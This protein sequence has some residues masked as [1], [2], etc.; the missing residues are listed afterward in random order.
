MIAAWMAAV[1]TTMAWSGAIMATERMRKAK[2][3]RAGAPKQ[4]WLTGP[5]QWLL[6]RSGALDKM[7]PLATGL[8]GKLLIL[9]GQTWSAE[10]SR[11]FI[12]ES[13]GIGYAALCA[14]TWLAILSGESTLLYIGLLLGVLVPAAKW[15]DVTGKVE[16]RKQD[17]VLLLPELLNKLMLLLGAGETLHRALARCAERNESH[18]HHPL[19]IELRRVNEAVRN[20]Q[21][22]AAAME[23]FSR[24]CGVQEVSV[25]TTTMLLNYKRGGDRLVLSLKE[26]SY[27]LWEKR[28]AVARSRGEEASAKLVFPLVGLFVVLMVLVAS[29][30]ILMMRG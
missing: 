2:G 5:C 14:G 8:H 25:F 4:R 26:L 3:I 6:E 11:G 22:F 19:L 7:Q 17:I 30:A 21:S 1:L 10:A 15:K 16:R 18:A 9:H 20:G 12:A 24:R 23:S 13:I 27:S 29:P 28:K